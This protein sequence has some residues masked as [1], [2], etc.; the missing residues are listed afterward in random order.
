MARVFAAFLT[1]F[2]GVAIGLAGPGFAQELEGK[3]SIGASGGL[4]LFMADD[5][6]SPDFWVTST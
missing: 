3:G 1:I 2:M 6:M 4:M 5:D